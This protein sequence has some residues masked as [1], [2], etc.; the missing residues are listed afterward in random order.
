MIIYQIHITTPMKK[1]MLI[2]SAIFVIFATTVFITQ[3]ASAQFQPYPGEDPSLPV[4]QLQLKL[5][6]KDGNFIAY[7]EPT[8][9][10]IASIPRTH[11]WLDTLPGEQ[12]TKDGEIFEQI[13]Y[14]SHYR[15]SGDTRQF[16]TY[17]QSYGG[18]SILIFRHDGY[19]AGEGDELQIQWNIIRTFN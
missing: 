4:I 19:L 6:D 10:Y 9:L 16:A 18:T 7:I 5:Y 14:S 2:I 15:F 17:Q 8:T 13:E 3:T 12:F 1:T 11:Q